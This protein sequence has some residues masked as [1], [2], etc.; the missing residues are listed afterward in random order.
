MSTEGVYSRDMGRG[1]SREGGG[2]LTRTS[3]RRAE[4]RTLRA[5][6]RTALSFC[7]GCQRTEMAQRTRTCSL[8]HTLATVSLALSLSD[9]HLHLAGSLAALRFKYAHSIGRCV[10][11]LGRQRH[12][13]DDIDAGTR[14]NLIMWNKSQAPGPAVYLFLSLLICLSIHLSSIPPPPLPPVLTGRVSSLFPY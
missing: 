13:A 3:L 5:P 10:V 9:S 6:P 11:H 14:V 8:S 2:R 12:G 4:G 1:N 7:G